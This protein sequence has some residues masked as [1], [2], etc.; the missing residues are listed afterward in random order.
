MSREDVIAIAELGGGGGGGDAARNDRARLAAPVPLAALLPASGDAPAGC[1]HDALCETRD[2]VAWAAASKAIVAR[3]QLRVGEAVI[4]ET[5]FAPA[6]EAVVD[7]MLQ[8][9]RAIG[10]KNALGWSEK[11]EQWRRRVMWSRDSGDDALPDLSDAALEASLEEWLAPMLPGVTSISALRKLDG[12]GLLRC[13][14]DYESSRRVEASC[15]TH[16]VVPS[17]SKL[18]V[19]YGAPGGTPVLRA[20]L[21]ELFGMTETPRAGANK[22]VAME[23]HLLSPAGRPVQVTTDLKSFWANAYHDV[24]KEMRGRYPKHYWPEDPT[25]AEATN[26]AKPRKT[27]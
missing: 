21:Q 19:D 22:T 8:G 9:V 14:V 24:A 1:L 6:P 4:R 7:A 3:R 20:R 25:T 13:M 27:K 16:V 23:V 17:G 10:V 2:V 18:P 12:D 26:R 15:P 11:T 5:A